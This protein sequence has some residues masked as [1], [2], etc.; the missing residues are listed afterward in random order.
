MRLKRFDEALLPLARDRVTLALAAYRSGI[1][2]L[3]T[4]LEARR[5]EIDLRLQKLQLAAE[6]GRARAQLIY[7]LPEEAAK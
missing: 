3:A 4:V 7:F 2:P 5:M 1:T 6:Q